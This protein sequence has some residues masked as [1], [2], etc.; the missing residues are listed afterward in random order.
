[1][2]AAR[3]IQIPDCPLSGRDEVYR[4]EQIKYGLDAGSPWW[5]RVFFRVVFM[6]V[7]RLARKL[8]IPALGAFDAEGRYSW[9]EDQG[10]YT[11]REEAR[12]ACQGEF[13]RVR[14]SPLNASLP[15]ASCEFACAE[16]PKGMKRFRHG[17]T[18]A[19]TLKPAAEITQEHSTVKKLIE[20]ADRIRHKAQSTTAP[21]SL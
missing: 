6:P 14:A 17:R 9:V 5:R 15:A 19:L 2:I 3:E 7:N 20:Q 21:A 18:L 13:W 10:T 12:N 1:M 11:E 8:G 4:V 16:Y